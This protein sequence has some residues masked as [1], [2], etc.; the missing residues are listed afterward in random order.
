MEPFA[1][2]HR[3]IAREGV[4]AAM[5][6]LRKAEEQSYGELQLMEANQKIR[7]LRWSGVAGVLSLRLRW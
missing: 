4:F 1:L 2:L 3:D 7:G 5:P 6:Y